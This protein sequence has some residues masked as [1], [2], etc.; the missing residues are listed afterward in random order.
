MRCVPIF[1]AL[2]FS[3]VRKPG[4]LHPVLLGLYKMLAK[5]QHLEDRGL[6]EDFDDVS[7]DRA[8]GLYVLFRLLRCSLFLKPICIATNP[9]THSPPHRTRGSLNGLKH[10]KINTPSP[11]APPS[12]HHTLSER[13]IHPEANSPWTLTFADKFHGL[14][15]AHH[16]CHSQ[17]FTRR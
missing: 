6:E 7:S 9:S 3:E 4:V 1:P 11:L 5:G 14:G 16:R 17:T 12:H 13:L 8:L 10:K 2:C 15:V